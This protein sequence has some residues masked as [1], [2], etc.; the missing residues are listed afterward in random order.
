MAE[1]TIYNAD[2]LDI[3]RGMDADV[4]ITDPPYTE[5]THDG[6]RTNRK[7]NGVKSE[8]FIDF[9]SVSFDFVRIAFSL[10]KPKKWLISFLDWRMVSELELSPPD[11]LEFIRFGVWTKPNAMPQLTGDRPGMGWEAI[12]FL[13]PPGKKIWN[14]G[15]HSSVYNFGTARWGNFGCSYH[16]TEKPIKLLVKLIEDFTNPGDT[17][18]DPFMGSGTTGVACMIAD[19]NFIGIELDPG[20]FKIA[21]ERIT[22]AQHMSRGEFVPIVD[23]AESMA[24]FPLFAL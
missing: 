3:M 21:Q 2:C 8:K 17:I 14:G 16:P 13:H 19:R 1:F 10:A 7:L 4:V 22:K 5:K 24:D 23:K 12:A 20:Y 11:G 9:E 15:G 6:A 18:L